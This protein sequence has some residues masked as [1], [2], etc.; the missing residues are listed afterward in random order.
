MRSRT[1]ALA[2]L[3]FISYLWSR[4]RIWKYY[5]AAFLISAGGISSLSLTDA[6]RR[7]PLFTFSVYVCIY[8]AVCA[9]SGCE[10]ADV[11]LCKPQRVPFRNRNA[12]FFANLLGALAVCSLRRGVVDPPL[13]IFRTIVIVELGVLATYMVVVKVH[14]DA[15]IHIIYV[16]ITRYNNLY[17]VHAILYF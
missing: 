11:H 14:K 8:L 16:E 1:H 10:N 9:R 15:N 12:D 13:H 2:L 3:L 5:A 7:L 4:S 17:F 6:P